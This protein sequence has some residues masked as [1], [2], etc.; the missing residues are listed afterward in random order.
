MNR[1]N[2]FFCLL[3]ILLGFFLA[4]LP[5]NYRKWS[6]Q[7]E[8]ISG[9]AKIAKEICQNFAQIGDGISYKD[10]CDDDEYDEL[11]KIWRVQPGIYGTLVT[12]LHRVHNI[13]IA[14]ISRNEGSGLRPD[15]YSREVLVEQQKQTRLLK[16]LESHARDEELDRL[17]SR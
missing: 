13:P 6:A 4:D 5:R 15:Y 2:A 1:K 7:R 11:Y 9:E 17:L 12:N 14:P 10:K 8:P 16:K 3:F